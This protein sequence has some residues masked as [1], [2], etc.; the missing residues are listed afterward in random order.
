MIFCEYVDGASNNVGIDEVAKVPTLE[1]AVPELQ[2]ARDLGVGGSLD[3]GAGQSLPPNGVVKHIDVP[4]A[5]ASDPAY[6]DV[7]V[8]LTFK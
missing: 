3:C 4:A 7:W 6:Y 1:A 5:S 2:T 8:T